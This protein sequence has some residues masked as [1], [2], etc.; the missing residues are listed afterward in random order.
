MFD[1]GKYL[2]RFK[3]IS[4][5]R[6]F[7]RDSAA[8]SIKEVCGI[9]IDPKKIDVKSGI[10]RVNERPII[11]NEIFIKKARILENLSKKT[12]GKIIDIL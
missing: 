8:E 7:L 4:E 10:A 11:K 5:S 1:I 6:N 9:E 12:G 3:K 2:D